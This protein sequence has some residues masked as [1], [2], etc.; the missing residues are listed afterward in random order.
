MHEVIDTCDTQVAFD[1]Y[2]CYL[3]IYGYN[4]IIKMQFF[5][6]MCINVGFTC[7]LHYWGSVA[8]LFVTG[9]FVE[10]HMSIM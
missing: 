7:R 1:G 10:G 2:I 9:I 4:V 3:H 8:C 6:C 5:T